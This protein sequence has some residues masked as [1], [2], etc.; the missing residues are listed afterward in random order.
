[1]KTLTQDNQTLLVNTITAN[2]GQDAAT[3]INAVKAIAAATG[4]EEGL[5]IAFADDYI[6]T[7][8]STPAVDTSIKNLQDFV[9]DPA[10]ADAVDKATSEK[11]LAAANLLAIQQATAGGVANEQQ[12]LIPGG[13]VIN[14]NTT[15]LQSLKLETINKQKMNIFAIAANMGENGNSM[16]SAFATIQGLNI[17]DVFAEYRA[18][19]SKAAGEIPQAAK[20]NNFN[21]KE[22]PYLSDRDTISITRLA[23]YLADHGVQN[24]LAYIPSHVKTPNI[25]QPLRR[26]SDKTEDKL[27]FE[28]HEKFVGYYLIE[29]YCILINALAKTMRFK[30]E[31]ILDFVTKSNIGFSAPLGVTNSDTLV[32]VWLANESIGLPNP[33]EFMQLKMDTV[34]YIKEITST[35]FQSFNKLKFDETFKEFFKNNLRNMYMQNSVQASLT[36][37]A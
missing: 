16:V 3:V 17:N 36:F 10:T 21:S 9:V 26:P 32:T 23:T 18:Y 28:E 22:Y 14:P 6:K 27:L 29:T 1:M 5:A 11:R 7:Q 33:I 24:H 12:Q 19:C 13:V 15:P 31:D 30:I 2:N 8:M 20:M 25:Y 4:I 37:E 35:T 34:F